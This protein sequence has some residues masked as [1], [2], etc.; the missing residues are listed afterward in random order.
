MLVALAHEP[1]QAMWT[2]ADNP[3]RLFWFIGGL[4]M[5]ASKQDRKRLGE[6]AVALYDK[7][8]RDNSY[9]WY[10]SLNNHTG[11]AKDSVR[12]FYRELCAYFP[13]VRVNSDL[14]PR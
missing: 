5:L 9:G 8:G 1:K 4:W 13:K 12:L 6:F 7:Y 11:N 14:L 10:K 3:E 2:G